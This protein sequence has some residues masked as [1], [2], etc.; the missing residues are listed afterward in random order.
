MPAAGLTL[1]DPP[2]ASFQVCCY[3]KENERNIILLEILVNPY[4]PT[5]PGQ[6]APF[7]NPKLDD[8]LACKLCFQG[9]CEDTTLGVSD[10]SGNFSK[11]FPRKMLDPL[12]DS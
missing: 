3:S 7:K 8:E 11:Q 10:M 5:T 1:E 2:G 12:A 9:E 6:L 4:A